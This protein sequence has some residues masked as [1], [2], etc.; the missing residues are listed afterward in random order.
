[1]SEVARIDEAILFLESQEVP[2]VERALV[3][4]KAPVIGV[5]LLPREIADAGGV[6]QAPEQ[7]A[8]KAH[9]PGKSLDKIEREYILEVFRAEKENRSA[10]AKVLGISRSTL[11]EKLKKYGVK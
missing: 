11:L 5:D 2:K 7:P 1:M 8:R 4:S 6:P 10:T 9:G 3:L